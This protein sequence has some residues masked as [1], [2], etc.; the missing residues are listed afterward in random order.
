MSPE[1]WVYD[2]A[3]AVARAVAARLVSALG[4]L[5]QA[6][7]LPDLCLTG[8]TIATRT[9]EELARQ[10]VQASVDWTRVTLWWGDERFVATDDGDRNAEPTLQ[11][12][13]PLGLEPARVHPMPGRDG[14]RDLDQAASDYAEE[15]GG[16]SFDICLLGLGPDGHV[17]SLFPDH[18]SAREAGEVIA[19]RDSP[20][21]PPERIS[22]T[23]PVL[24]RSREVWFLVSGEDKADAAAK[25]LRRTGPDPVPA[26]GVDAAGSTVWLID[27]AAA[28]ELPDSVSR[29]SG[30]SP[31]Q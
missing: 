13:A 7:D 4:A 26:A 6:G 11:V 17:A 12:L 1:I 25:A 14:G 29:R 22:L 24:N 5:Q 30:D 23:L 15:L 31:R 3:E 18:P 8:G 19:V 2:D 16:T 9:Y 27:R 21:P 10:G 20:K 28:S